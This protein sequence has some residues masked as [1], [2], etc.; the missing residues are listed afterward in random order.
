M[1]DD[2][3]LWAC[4]LADDVGFQ[5]AAEPLIE[6]TVGAASHTGLVRPTNQDHFAAVRRTRS[7][8]I[9][10]TNVDVTG[11]DLAAQH[12]Y[13]LIVTDGV[14][15]RECGQLASELVLRIG[16][17]LGSRDPSWIMKFDRSQWSRICEQ[18]KAYVREIQNALREQVRANP[19][20]AGMATTWTCACLLDSEVVIAHVGDSRAYLLRDGDFWQLTRDQTVAQA[21]Q[22]KG[23]PAE[24]AALYKN[25]LTN[26]LTGEDEDAFVDV[27][28]VALEDGD[29]LLLCTDGLT[30]MSNDDEIASTLTAAPTA[31][32]ACDK[33]IELALGHGG[34][35]NITALVAEFR[36]QPAP[37]SAGA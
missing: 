28:H 18:V 30:N 5:P 19:Q 29:R 23:V 25:S 32:S 3:T 17:E 16:W 12:A 4:P 6:V 27:D 24:Q 9:L 20:Y 26:A 36:S 8:E 7:R 2:E 15:S 35:D 34:T 10:C 37:Q 33:L 22:D 13:I 31:Q 21:L 1:S 14:G 11:L